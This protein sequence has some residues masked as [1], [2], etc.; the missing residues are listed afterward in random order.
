MELNY[1]DKNAQAFFDESVKID[2]NDLYDIFLSYLEKDAYILD[3]GCGSGRDSKVFINKGYEVVSFDSSVE[4]V[5]LASVYIGK[6]VKL[7][8]F[9]QLDETDTYNGIWA[10][11]SLIHVPEN[12]L[13]GTMVLL[14]NALKKNGYM[15][16]SFKYG[17]KDRYKDGRHF[18]DMNQDRINKLINKISDFTIIKTWIAPDKRQ[19]KTEKWFNII[20]KKE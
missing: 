4:L 3:A 12:K 8:D 14:K 2:L 13:S 17:G 18:T 15:Y 1:Y 5:K 20:L 10:C 9:S 6:R 19:G 11:A 7:M 16:L